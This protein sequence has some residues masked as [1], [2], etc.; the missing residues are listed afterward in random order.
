MRAF[1]H[2]RTIPILLNSGYLKNFKMANYS[3]KI[4]ENIT[5]HKSKS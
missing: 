1:L 2:N 5:E 4:D 3:I